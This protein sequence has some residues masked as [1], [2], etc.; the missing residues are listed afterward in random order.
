MTTGTGY[1]LD[2]SCSLILKALSG[3]IFCRGMQ[4]CDVNK[5]LKYDRIS[6]QENFVTIIAERG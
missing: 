6:F 2:H 1:P 3:E 5:A 4:K